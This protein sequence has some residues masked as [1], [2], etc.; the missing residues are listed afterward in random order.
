M[1]AFAEYLGDGEGIPVESIDAELLRI[2]YGALLWE[3]AEKKI[4]DGAV[5]DN[6]A[7]QKMIRKPCTETG[8][9]DFVMI[10]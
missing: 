9:S 1:F 5:S 3:Y 4:E 2:R 6:E 7:P 10:N 8:N